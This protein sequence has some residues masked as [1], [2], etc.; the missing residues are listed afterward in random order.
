MAYFGANAEHGRWDPELAAEDM[1]RQVRN[2]VETHRRANEEFRKGGASWYPRANELATQIGQGNTERGAGIIAAL[3]P[4]TSWESNIK[5]AHEVVNTGT[6]THLSP[7][8]IS[9]AQR[10]HQGEHPLDVLG[11]NKVRSFYQNI[12]DP[13]NAEP[14]TID[15]HAYDIA[16][17]RPFVGLGGKSKRNITVG[18]SGHKPMSED[19]GLSAKKRYEHFSEAYRRASGELEIPTPNVTQ[20]ITWVTHRGAI[21]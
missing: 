8:A 2:I 21:G 1:P 5:K 12:Q 14:V 9:K 13:S 19:L 16:M 10:I 11:G 6:T 17:G 4:L 15:R 7:D 3:S 20:A 18:P